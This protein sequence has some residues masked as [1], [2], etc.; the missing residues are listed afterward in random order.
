MVADW[1]A[2]RGWLSSFWAHGPPSGWSA[3]NHAGDL[4]VPDAVIVLA[5]MVRGSHP[6]FGGVVI[7]FDRCTCNCSWGNE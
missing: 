1:G 3:S 2:D 7:V 6:A 5:I 4:V